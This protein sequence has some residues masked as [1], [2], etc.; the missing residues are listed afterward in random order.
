MEDSLANPLNP[1]N[2]AVYKTYVESRLRRKAA[3]PPAFAGFLYRWLPGLG[4]LTFVGA[5]HLPEEKKSPILWAEHVVSDAI[6]R[7]RKGFQERFDDVR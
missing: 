6:W 5:H 3:I 4:L 2:F 7:K 1:P